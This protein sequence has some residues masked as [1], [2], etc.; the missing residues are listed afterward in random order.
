MNAKWSTEKSQRKTPEP[1][2]VRVHSQCL[3]GD[4]FGSMRCDCGDQLQNAMKLIAK[5][6]SNIHLHQLPR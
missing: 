5:Y 2:L 3:T 4:T 1:V 6:L